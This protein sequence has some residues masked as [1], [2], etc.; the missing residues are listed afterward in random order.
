MSELFRIEGLSK[1]FGGLQ[2][3]KDFGLSVGQGERVALI[4]P[5]GAGKT[6]V[7][8]LINGYYAPDAGRI[9]LSGTNLVPMA[10]RRRIRQGL[11]RSFQNIRLIPHLTVLENVL[12]GAHIRAGGPLAMAIPLMLGR[13]RALREEARALLAEAGLSAHE[14]SLAGGL[15]YGLRKRVEVVRALMA[16]PRLLL[17][18]EPCAGLNP[19]ERGALLEE[20]HRVAEAGVTLLVVEHDMHF[21]GGLCSRAAVLNF[22]EKIA[23][24]SPAEVARDPAVIE[25]Y[26]GHAPEKYAHA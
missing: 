3:V 23:E 7:F 1:A 9:L 12:L 11:A 20:L 2:I 5:N 10:P 22:G 17:L 6:T 26:L 15:P 19:T 24:G 16:R 25:A 4:G 14:G 8:N 21:V 18:D 13:G